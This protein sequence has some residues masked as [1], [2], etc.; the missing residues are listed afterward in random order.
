ME[1]RGEVQ[2]F[3]LHTTEILM[4]ENMK[5]SLRLSRS[6]IVREAIKMYYEM[7]KEQSKK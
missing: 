3:R 5:I 6:E 7:M 2:S 1:T 4:L